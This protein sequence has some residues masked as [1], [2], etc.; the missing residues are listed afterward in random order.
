[1]PSNS[2]GNQVVVRSA[3]TV[4]KDLP[5]SFFMERSAESFVS[6]LRS[7]VAAVLEKRATEVTGIDGRIPWSWRWPQESPAMSTVPCGWT[8][9]AHKL[10][11]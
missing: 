3:T 4:Y 9:Y 7:L 8:R 6:E 2:Y 11:P 1:L 5:L 10:A